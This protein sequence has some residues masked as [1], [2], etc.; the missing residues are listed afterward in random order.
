MQTLFLS[1]VSS[2]FAKL[3]RRLANLAQ[4][5]KKC[6]VR[7]QDDFFHRGIETHKN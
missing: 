1:T 4:R 7:H 2:E 5:S 3:R 6:Q